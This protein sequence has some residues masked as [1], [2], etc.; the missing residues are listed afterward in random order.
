M[1]C[2]ASL[3]IL[4]IDRGCLDDAQRAKLARTA[5]RNLETIISELAAARR[6]ICMA[7]SALCKAPKLA[8]QT[9]DSLS[10]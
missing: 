8:F 5:L 4:L 9:A 1:I 10:L 7:K 6:N 2:F 3:S